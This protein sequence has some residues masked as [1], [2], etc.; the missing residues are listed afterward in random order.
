MKKAITVLTLFL[1]LLLPFCVHAE[2]GKAVIRNSDGKILEKNE[3]AVIP[4]SSHD[5]EE[6]D[7]E[8]GDEE[9]EEKSIIPPKAENTTA[10]IK[11]AQTA[12]ENA[13]NGFTEGIINALFEGSVTIFET[14]VSE[15]EGG[16]VTYDIRVRSVHPYEHPLVL[17]IQLVSFCF[18]ILI[19]AITI[20]GTMLV[21]SF[22][23][24]HPEAYGDMKRG[25]SGQYKPYNPNRVHAACTWSITRP[26]LYFAGFILFVYGRNYLITSMPQTASGVIGSAS[27]NIVIWGITGLS[28]F[29]GAFQTSMGEY[30]IYVF[31]ALLFITCMVTDFLIVLNAQDA[32]KKIE[33]IAW[34]AFG[35]FCLC[36][37][38][39]MFCTTF[40]VITSQW[41][42]E[43]IF[44]TSGIVAGGFIN[45]VIFAA[46][47]VYA[48]LKGKKV[49]GV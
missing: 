23:T 30:G 31:G 1:L 36:D 15:D 3:Q 24:K 43:E 5:D 8:G 46:L 19:T 4:G 16:A 7:E 42:G 32:A 33:I 40:G 48:V 29:I 2:T 6:D 45:L 20:L 35:L 47:V 41:R 18:L 22:Q 34:G 25:L 26:L 10:S 12:F 49:L 28:I 39:N 21:S 27:D 38:I 17:P 14:D 44:I 13:L 37:L 11:A 9:T